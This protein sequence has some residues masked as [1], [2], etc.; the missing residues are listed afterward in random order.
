MLNTISSLR[1]NRSKCSL[2]CDPPTGFLSSHQQKAGE[3]VV[4]S[5]VDRC[6]VSWLVAGGDETPLGS[7]GV[8]EP[9]AILLSIA[10]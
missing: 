8:E 6:V 5:P 4:L 1:D 10:R 2:V 3:L 7:N 9:S